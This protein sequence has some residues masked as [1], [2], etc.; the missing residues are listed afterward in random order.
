MLNS[1]PSGTQKKTLHSAKRL[2]LALL[3]IAVAISLST[4]ITDAAETGSWTYGGPQNDYTYGVLA[5]TDG[6]YLMVGTT[7]SYGAG[8]S[9]AWL[10]KA[11]SNGL[12][13]WNRT[14]G[15]AG[16]DYG[17]N[18][19]ATSDGGY[20]LVGYTDS[21]GPSMEGWLIKVDAQGNMQ[22]NRTY[23]NAGAEYTANLLTTPDG[24]YLLIGSVFMA[25]ANQCDGLIVKTDAS[26]VMQWNRTIGG[27][28]GSDYLWDAIVEH[29]G[30]VIVG[31]TASF[32]A[33]A[34]D[35]WLLKIGTDGVTLWNHTY[36]GS[37]D[38]FGWWLTK[39]SEGGYVISGS[40]SSFGA[41]KFDAWIL[42]TSPEGVVQWNQT[43]GGVEDDFG[44]DM[45]GTGDGGYAVA[46]YT[47]SYGKNG[48]AWLIQTDA[49]GV[50]SWNQ[51][52][53][54]AMFDQA[55][56]LAVTMEGYYALTAC[57]D[58]FGAGSTDGWL[59]IAKAPISQSTLTPLPFG[60]LATVLI[61]VAAL[62]AVTVALFVKFRKYGSHSK[63]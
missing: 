5:A 29:G 13:E 52:F 57:T 53:G 28:V 48:L 8:K 23:N 59:I 34:D 7:S 17:C 31:S 58:S 37:F 26:G 47:F 22:W 6:G 9:D 10:I 43:F 35:A 21:Y 27:D 4:Q 25:G 41:G 51:T 44:Y 3:L 2:L 50:L 60:T 30:Y 39:S 61:T 24:G 49:I 42:G 55:Q 32:G 11:N 40:T 45:V 14:Y 38:D 12:A 63:H 16:N 1:H 46:G 15:G 36:G 18:M 54:G 20:A 33:G 19:I 62:A 56:G